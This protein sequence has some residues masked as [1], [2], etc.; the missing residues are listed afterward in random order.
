MDPKHLFVDERPKG[1]C[2]Y[3]GGR[4]DTVDHLACRVVW[5]R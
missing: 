4:P 2:V 5:N 1:G 3:S